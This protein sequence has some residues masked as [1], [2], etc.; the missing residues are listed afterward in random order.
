M[1]NLYYF[2]KKNLQL[3]YIKLNFFQV[4]GL[5]LFIK[6]GKKFSLKRINK[7]FDIRN[8]NYNYLCLLLFNQAIFNEIKIFKEVNDYF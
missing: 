1:R 6:I 2:L 7:T 5:Q 4:L 3:E 8:N